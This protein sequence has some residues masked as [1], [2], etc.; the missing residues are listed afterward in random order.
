M[1]ARLASG[2]RWWLTALLLALVLP[3]AGQ[4]SEIHFSLASGRTYLPGET[5]TV[6]VYAGG[7]QALDFR[8][9]RI[10]DPVKFFTQLEDRHAFGGRG[11]PLPG[12]STWI[13]RFHDW[14]RNLRADARDFFRG[15]FSAASRAAIREWQLERERAARPA[16]ATAPGKTPAT[17]FAEVPVLNQQQLVS[18]WRQPVGGGRAW[19]SATVPIE[20]PGKGLYLVEAVHQQLRAY[21]IV[22]VSNLGIITKAAPG[23]VLAFVTHRKT[24]A[25]AAGAE[26][27]VLTKAAAAT[28]TTDAD[29]LAETTLEE[30]RPDE[31]LVLARTG[32]EFAVASIYSW[33]LWND[34]ARQLTGAVYTE[35]PVYRPTHTVNFRGVVRLQRGAELKP[36][37]PG[38]AQVE[39]Q[40][41]EGNAV[42][43]LKARISAHGT[44]SGEFTLAATAA[45]GYYSIVVRV[46]EGQVQGGFQVEEYKKP[47]YE[48]RVTPRARR[49]L[50]GETIEASIEAKY[51]YGEPVAG[52]RVTWVVHTSRYWL[53]PEDEEEQGESSGDEGE[54]DGY[55]YGGEQVAEQSGVLDA[56]GKLTISVPTT[57]DEKRRYDM[58]YRIEARV[59]DAA[60]RE[61]S[62]RGWA[63]ATYGSF[64]LR[65]EP[66]QY[67]YASG[68][69][70]RF[71]VQA[72]DYDGKPV[73]TPL[74]LELSH[75]RYDTRKQSPIS[76]TEGRTDAA[77]QTTLDLSLPQPGSLTVRAYAA[78]PEGREVEAT[79]WVWVT[80]GGEGP[81]WYRGRGERVQIVTDK[82]SYQPGDVAKVLI[83][84]GVPEAHLLV[85]AEGRDLLSRQ[86]LHATGA[87]LSVDVPIRRE[88]ASNFFVNV[89]FLRENQ[90]YEGSKKVKV[91][92]AGQKL[93]VSV[94]SS[95]LQ[96]IPG[97]AAQFTLVARDHA[98]RPVPGA[99]ISLG[100]VDEAIYAIRPD[101]TPDL[102]QTFY[103]ETYNRVSTGT[104]LSYYFHGQAGRRVMPLARLRTRRELA[105]LKPERLVEPKVRKAFP[106]TAYWRAALVT[107]ADGRAQA[108]FSFPDSLTTWRATARAI[109]RDTRAGGAVHRVIVRKN[110][111]LHL[112]VPRFFTE[113][114]QVTVYTIVRNYLAEEKKARV[115]LAVEGLE[116]LEGATRDVAIPSR[117]EARL[118]WRVRASSSREA[119]L[120]GKAL[121]NE[122]SDAVE[123][124][125]PVVPFGVKLW[126]ARAGSLGGPAEEA[127]AQLA[128]P[129][130]A[131]PASR[132]L[133]VSVSP[134]L[135]GTVFGALEYLTNYPYGCVEQTMSSFLPNV[136][137]TGA[138]KELGI[139]SNVNEAELQKKTREGLERLYRFQH[140]DGGW[141]W[142]ETD[143]SHAFMTAYVL[144][145]LAQAQ[146]AG[147]QV[148]EYRMDQARTWLRAAF[149]RES[150]A[151]A[152]LRAYLAYSLA[153]AGDRD[154]AVRDA[155]WAQRADLSNYGRALLGLAMYRAADD[156]SKELAAELE[157]A[158]KSDDRE[159][160]WPAE[161]DNLLD[162]YGDAS[163]EATAH[164]MK[165]LMRHNPQSPL[166]PKAAAW[167]VN[168]RSGGYYWY[169]TKQTAMVIFGLL[170]YV[171][172]S[173]ELKPD[174]AVSVWVNDK[175]LAERRFTE[176]D[177]VAPSA[178]VLRVP[179]AQLRDANTI[180]VTKKGTGRLYWSARAEYFSTDER[181]ART[182]AV[183]L[184]VIRE[185]F[186]LT[187][188]QE[189][190]K[191]VHRLEPLAGAVAPGDVVVARL[192]LTGGDWRYLMIE[193][194][195]PAGF[196]FIERDDLYEIKEKPSWW[197]WWFTRREFH[198]HR[199]VF[200]QTWFNRGQTQYLYLLKAVNPGRFRVSPARVEPMYQPQY[201]A[202]SDSKLIEVLAPPASA[203]PPAAPVSGPGTGAASAARPPAE[204]REK[205]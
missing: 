48:V 24:G 67:I 164:A 14:K 122:E 194:P 11:M 188:A 27:R 21:T 163:P 183:S 108:R 1:S 85:T 121:T 62:G 125:L 13:E 100:V 82:K 103:G 61:I 137:V 15:Q 35:R 49:V 107:G 156:R 106:D 192:T 79:T 28:L 151:Y 54:E 23:R 139:K 39:V 167:L 94:E 128:F 101:M 140:Q 31:A 159:A 65:I 119:K 53:Y 173:G 38:E 148:D 157:R 42:H 97:E 177:A 180:R 117:G 90:L 75:W 162:F 198:D 116:V 30:P 200:F 25:P 66:A 166:L 43:R 98:G 147:V 56:A 51:Y 5:P 142:W 92:P 7:V 88:Y 203:V 44:L 95:K 50:Q 2:R 32:D 71:R 118:D 8:V 93:S 120:L 33:Y 149:D 105:Q 132:N 129:A 155:V 172:A 124:T 104:S 199:A 189:G 72:M 70:A 59:T 52:A 136:V 130:S 153:L 102:V 60:N 109:T 187:P 18:A 185:Y 34:P 37:P 91:P 169:S 176:A 29:G 64:L 145:G 9:Y 3:V 68:S 123:L 135:A 76:T 63:L 126:E 112:A 77:G 152:D 55:D 204:G 127:T 46:G 86:V 110:L 89:A 133:E 58:R 22:S 45:L 175:L 113:G 184:N 205:P 36:V 154:L 144:A 161:R 12:A 20:I 84:T 131:T 143:E 160:F 141:G 6:Q 158:A 202:A 40:D 193:D 41:S 16:S 19:E 134:S 181:L 83:I 74:R 174:L 80:G 168:H 201:F 186:K 190:A 78:T 182:G 81:W 191:I 195:I 197:Y 138:L 17:Q 10:N 4:E 73:A 114:D 69:R 47:E 115:S 57:V 87:T 171:K 26:V 178:P 146:E 170:D 165:L 150:R 99:E 196:E 179:L 111:V 96:Y